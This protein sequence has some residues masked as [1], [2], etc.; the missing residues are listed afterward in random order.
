MTIEEGIQLYLTASPYPTALQNRWYKYKAPQ[1]SS[2]SPLTY[3][4]ISRVSVD[5]IQTH[6][7]PPDFV[8]R[9]VQ[10][11]I[12]GKSQSDGAENADVL[13]R[14]LNGFVGTMGT[15]PVRAV[16]WASDGYFFEDTTQQHHFFQDFWFRY[17]E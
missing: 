12:W 2:S 7:G 3:G 15:L 14:L 4:V 1:G 10:L 5:P 6:E 17:S 11:S 16:H 13:R 8:Q 9:R